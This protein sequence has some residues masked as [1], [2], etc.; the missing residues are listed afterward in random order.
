M[1]MQL[2]ATKYV[3]IVY[4]EYLEDKFKNRILLLG[5]S[6]KIRV[7]LS[8][9]STSSYTCIEGKKGD[10]IKIVISI[11]M[12]IKTVG[13]PSVLT[14]RKEIDKYLK[15]T[16]KAI[17]GFFYHELSHDLHT[18][19][20]SREIIDYPKKECVGFIHGIFNT[21]EDD[22]I[23]Y[24][25][26]KVFKDT[27]PYDVNPKIYFKYLIKQL[28]QPA[29]DKYTADNSVGNFLNYLLLCLRVGSK[30]IVNQNPIF[31]KY[32]KDLIPLFTSVLSENNPTQRV[33][34]S[35]VCAEWIMQNIPELDWSKEYSPSEA[36]SGMDRTGSLRKA[37]QPTNISL[38][39]HGK[40]LGKKI[41]VLVS[42]S[43]NKN[44]DGNE[45]TE[46]TEEDL[47][48]AEVIELD[49]DEQIEESEESEEESEENEASEEN[50]DE[51]TENSDEDELEDDLEI[52]E[53]LEEEKIEKNVSN[54]IFERMSSTDPI[55]TA[56]HEFIIAKEYYESSPAIINAIEKLEEENQDMVDEICAGIKLYRNRVKPMRVERLT[57]GRLSPRILAREE[58]KNNL[59]NRVFYKKIPTGKLKN[60]CFII[61]C[62][63]SGSM[64]GKKSEISTKACVALA[65]VGNQLEI[66][67]KIACFVEDNNSNYTIIEKDF[68]DNYEESKQYLGINSSS[69]IK[70]Y[71]KLGSLHNF[72][73]NVDEVNIYHLYQEIKTLPYEYKVLIVLSD[74][75]T[76][77]DAQALRNLVTQMEKEDNIFVIGV[78]LCSMAVLE[79]Y[80][81]TQVF[82]TIP[83]LEKGLASYLI[84][85]F[86]NFSK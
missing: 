49:D 80:N 43:N 51:D 27:L 2:T 26:S 82:R 31:V 17:S 55:V 21:L 30:N 85:V 70:S 10:R 47:E 86:E 11:P 62:D 12:V 72:R 33:H 32:Q 18:D 84:E 73:G 13:I 41:V 4:K 5:D 22:V 19:L 38:S 3:Q 24:L 59:T 68:S 40:A 29:A 52:D 75:L 76:C 58:S 46:L 23:E 25:I 6:R 78:G 54:E 53:K 34:K 57:S 61:L 16:Q 7:V 71:N 63:N 77:G 60:P 1:S 48:N 56:E 69:L 8:K 44:E 64:D 50:K 39:K 79:I 36:L 45:E 15:D 74:G 81:H 65:Q 37:L 28:F 67:T 20:Q 66:P 42:K 35:V 9:D 83:E 14:D